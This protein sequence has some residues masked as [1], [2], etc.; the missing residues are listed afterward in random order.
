MNTINF[1]GEQLRIINQVQGGLLV[2]APVGT[3]KTSVLSAR[4]NTAIAAGFAPNRILCL[5]FTNRAAKEMSDRV[6]ISQPEIHRQLTIK[7]FHGLCARMLRIEAEAIGLPSDFAIYDDQ[8]CFTI[9]KSLSRLDEDKEVRALLNEIADCKS[10][11]ISAE[12]TLELTLES[13]FATLDAKTQRIAV[14]YQKELSDRHALDF[15][16]LV[17]YTRAMLHLDPAIAERWRDRFDF[18]QVDEVQDTHIGEYEVVRHLAIKSGNLALIGDLDQTI[19]SWRGS[20]PDVVLNQFKLDF[21]PQQFSLTQNY[22]A[23]QTLLRAASAF[24]EAFDER[25]TAISPADECEVGEKILIHHAIDETQE[26]QWIAHQIRSL[27]ASSSNFRYNRVA[28][29][30]R[31]HNRTRFVASAL[32]QVNVPAVTVDQYQFFRRCSVAG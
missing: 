31:T 7:T 11:A 26:A 2:L 15:A 25:H 21:Q 4:V 8:D 6:A 27:S 9:L 12:L 20:E 19:Y 1:N 29:L 22:R 10:K 32:K 28:V 3:G 5:T 13:L 17:F 16:D 30:T 23:T 18:V 14:L 24:A